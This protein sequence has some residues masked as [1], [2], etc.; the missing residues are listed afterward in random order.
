MRRRGWGLEGVDLELSKVSS[1][2][3]MARWGLPSQLRCFLERR[4]EFWDG[5]K[6]LLKPKA[7]VV[8]GGDKAE[9]MRRLEMS[10]ELSMVSFRV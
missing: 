6:A 2:V 3:E 1:R 10:L 5:W 7:I 9:G 8:A 4:L